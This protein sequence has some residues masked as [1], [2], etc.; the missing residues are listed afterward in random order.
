MPITRFRL[1]LTV[2]SPL[3]TVFPPGFSLYFP[4][5][6]SVIL[7]DK[8][9][10]PEFVKT[11][12][13]DP[14]ETRFPPTLMVPVLL[15]APP[16]FTSPAMVVSKP[17]L[18]SIAVLLLLEVKLPADALEPEAMLIVELELSVIAFV[19]VSEPLFKFSVPPEP[20]VVRAPTFI[21]PVE[22]DVRTEPPI[23]FS[24]PVTVRLPVV[25]VSVVLF[26]VKSP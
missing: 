8:L 16:M 3:T 26:N 7:P 19:T 18:L 5:L 25:M 24:V 2:T 14:D 10:V 4:E 15:T 6:G 22:F 1:P 20:L 21:A 11:D 17:A 12:E 9:N 23:K 13:D